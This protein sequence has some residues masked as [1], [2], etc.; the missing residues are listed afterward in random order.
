MNSIIKK[1]ILPL[2]T[3]GAGISLVGS[4]TGTVAWYQYSIRAQA[5]MTGTTAHCSKLLQVS[6]DNGETWGSDLDMATI[7]EHTNDGNPVRF[8]PITTGAMEKDAPL[9]SRERDENPFI[10]YGSPKFGIDSYDKW[11]IA[12]QNNYA[13]FNLELRSVDVDKDFGKAEQKLLTNDVYLTDLTIQSSVATQDIADAVRVHFKVTSSDGTIKYYLFARNSEEIAVGS[14][15]DVNNDGKIDKVVDGYDWEYPD[16]RPDCMYGEEG[17]VQTSYLTNDPNII[18]QEADNLDLSGG[19]AIGKTGTQ[20]LKIEVTIWVEGWAELLHGIDGNASGDTETSI[21]DA[22]QYDSKAFF[23]GMR[24]GV[25]P[26]DDEN[27]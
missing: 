2:L 8:V 9:P 14:Y 19:E 13:R 21:W 7:E 10:F 5:A 23:V 27:E 25:D 11:D 20:S 1:F 26:H 17:A 24:F 22:D 3:L 18:P 12:T 4:V 15:L 16:G 6:C